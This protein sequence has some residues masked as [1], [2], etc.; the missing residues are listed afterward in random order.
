M[1]KY[2]MLSGS[3]LKM[4]ALITMMIDHTAFF[5]L[6][7][8]PFATATLFTV[9]KVDVTVYYICRLIGRTA[10]PIYC[11]LLTE[12]FAYT[13]NRKKYGANLLIFAVLSEPVWNLA[14]CGKF[15]YE[16]QNVFFT[17]FFGFLAIYF[18]EKF[19]DEK[20]L[21]CTAVLSV[22]IVATVFHADYGMNGVGL[23]LFMHVMREKAAARTIIGCCFFS[24]P[25]RVLPSFI[26][27]NFY[28]GK[29][30]FIRGKVG[31]YVF[32]AVYPLH[33]LVLYFIRLKYFGY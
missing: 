8:V 9:G 23:I 32:Y 29:R 19:K 24:K 7:S 5:I 18:Y 12:G 33:M 3:A 21:C 26:I 13:K 4:I 11:F 20:L 30:G 27:M 16:S 31:K 22:F 1:K 28:S 15:F 6:G 2:Q 17:L 10:F 25:F 14:H